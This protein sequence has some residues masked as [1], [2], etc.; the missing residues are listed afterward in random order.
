[1]AKF[2]NVEIDS[3]VLLNTSL[4]GLPEVAQI[5]T[6]QAQVNNIDKLANLPQFGSVP[7][8]SELHERLAQ[9]GCVQPTQHS[10][11]LSTGTPLGHKLDAA[12]RFRALA[13]VL[14][15]NHKY[16]ELAKLKLWT[17]FNKPV[18]YL[19]TDIKRYTESLDSGIERLKT[20]YDMWGYAEI[21]STTERSTASQIKTA[22]SFSFTSATAFDV[23]APAM[24]LNSEYLVQQ[25][26]KGS[27]RQTNIDQLS[28]FYRWHRAEKFIVTQAKDYFNYASQF[29]F[30]SGNFNTTVYN[31]KEE[32][33]EHLL[34]QVGQSD[35]GKNAVNAF[36]VLGILDT[37]ENPTVK[38][39]LSFETTEESTPISLGGL[40][41]PSSWDINVKHDFN[42][43]SVL[44]G[45]VQRSKEL[46]Y[47]QAKA[48][49]TEVVESYFVKSG[50]HIYLEAGKDL[51]LRSKGTLYLSGKKV[52][53]HTLDDTNIERLIGYPN[54]EMYEELNG[55]TF[56]R[57]K[58]GELLKD[59]EGNI[60][61][62]G[63]FG[64]PVPF[65]LGPQKRGRVFEILRPG[66]INVPKPRLEYEEV[67]N[68]SPEVEE[69]LKNNGFSK[70]IDAFNFSVGDIVSS[71]EFLKKDFETTA[72][73]FDGSELIGDL[74]KGLSLDNFLK[75]LSLD[76]IP[77]V[78]EVRNQ[79]DFNGLDL[80][81][82]S[83]SKVTVSGGE[84]DY[85]V[86]VLLP[87]I[88][89][90]RTMNYPPNLLDYP[91]SPVPKVAPSS[92]NNIWVAPAVTKQVLNKTLNPLNIGDTNGDA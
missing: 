43:F 60:L 46:I 80:N 31:T 5:D 61:V 10:K 11:T 65:N 64:F 59:V 2:D 6:A 57:D 28:C 92:N 81:P 87:D 33:Y 83:V 74:V 4:S 7:S 1:M 68:V 3:S 41:Q 52:V 35:E 27:F 76:V 84:L 45:I 14:G 15:V 25:A 38:K 86:S 90:S 24:I 19:P 82:A 55:P 42:L 91:K 17:E 30:F 89:G 18:S 32:R 47:Q 37:A 51:Y 56:I 78:G 49:I 75:G 63:A 77:G 9:I 16:D 44:A 72:G 39:D 88:P 67:L 26:S 8:A 36:N 69:V 85:T 29:S 12:G 53:I 22:Q 62:Q 34:T 21:G 40:D 71:L 50:N 20:V 70:A 73:A 54:A 13:E 48:L 66:Q 79:L 58:T 23:T